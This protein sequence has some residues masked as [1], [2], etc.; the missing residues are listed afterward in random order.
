[1]FE[2]AIDGD[3]EFGVGMSQNMAE[4]AHGGPAIDG[5]HRAAEQ[6]DGK[7]RQDPRR[8]VTHEN[9]DLVAPTNAES[10]QAFSQPA[11]GVAERSIRIAL[12]T[13]DQRLMTGVAGRQLVEEVGY[14]V[15]I[16][17]P[18]AVLAAESLVAG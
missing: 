9:A 1:M 12:L 18:H 4:L 8:P 16:G 10:V 15:G 2:K 14:G 13:A 17:R 6:Q 5:D 7:V 11:H 3:Q